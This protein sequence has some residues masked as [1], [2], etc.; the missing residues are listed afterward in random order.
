[1]RRMV[2]GGSL[3]AF[4]ACLLGVAQAEPAGPA[5]LRWPDVA[6]A[7]DRAEARGAA[8]QEPAGSITG[9]V[10]ELEL[11]FVQEETD[12]DGQRQYLFRHTEGRRVFLCYI[13][14]STTG[15]EPGWTGVFRGQV[16]SLQLQHKQRRRNLYLVRLL[17]AGP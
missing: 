4:A 1:M 14:G 7:L 2:R 10:A 17:A 6:A 8:A 13:A 12:A 9:R 11:E 5:A 16:T 3:A 15:R